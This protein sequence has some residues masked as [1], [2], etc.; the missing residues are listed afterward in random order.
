[1]A[2][3][4]APTGADDAEISDDTMSTTSEE[5]AAAAAEAAAEAAAAEVMGNDANSVE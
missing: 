4:V 5:A 3:A 1:M 2:P